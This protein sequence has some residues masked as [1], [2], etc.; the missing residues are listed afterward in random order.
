MLMLLPDA[1]VI[2]CKLNPVPLTRP[3][4]VAKST[5]A[6][7]GNTLCLRQDC[8]LNVVNVKVLPSFIEST[9]SA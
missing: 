2:H 9:I 8:V 5:T 4:V 1:F 7:K 3:K 6:A